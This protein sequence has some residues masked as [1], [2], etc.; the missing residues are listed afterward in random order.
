M[1]LAEE[2]IVKSTQFFTEEMS[3][4]QVPS[5]MQVSTQSSIFCLTCGGEFLL[6]VV[7]CRTNASFIARC[8]VACRQMRDSR[9]DA[10]FVRNAFS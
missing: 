5:S 4:T 8:I 3:G 2:E 7:V 6:F 1:S 9:S 10:L